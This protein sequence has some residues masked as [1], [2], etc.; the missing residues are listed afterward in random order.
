MTGLQLSPDGKYVLASVSESGNAKN[1]TIPQWITET[2]YVED[3]TGRSNVGDSANRSRLAIL[4]AVT[5]EVK[6]ADHGPAVSEV[7]REVDLLQP[8]W[9]EDGTRCA[10]EARAAD[11]KDRWLL[12]LD[13]AT[14]KTSVLDHEH[15][16]AWVAGG[17]GRSGAAAFG[18]MKNDREVYFQSER[19]GYSQLYAV[20]FDGGEPRALTSGQVGSA[21]GAAVQR[22]VALLSHRQQGFAL[23]KPPL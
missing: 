5:G 4:D 1:T 13:P 22:Q 9:S 23:R 11:N 15:D 18:W 20:A 10:V 3:E 17:S 16:D 12:A 21:G 2:A 6:W 19:T 8:V 14:G 7:Q